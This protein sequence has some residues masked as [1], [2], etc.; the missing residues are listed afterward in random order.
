MSQKITLKGVGYGISFVELTDE[1][2]EDFLTEVEQVDDVSEIEL[3]SDLVDESF[4]EYGIVLGEGDLSFYVDDKDQGDLL[5]KVFEASE[6]ATTDLAPKQGEN[7]VVYEA[8]ECIDCTIEVDEF[9]V[10][11]FDL[12]KQTLHL[13][14]GETR[15]IA[16]VCYGDIGFDVC[17]TT[18][19][20]RVYVVTKDQ[21]ILAF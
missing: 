13:P 3:V 4:Y 11:R 16:T 14:N 6:S 21:E 19:Y 7:L 20:G 2:L 9:D 18:S 10:S 1:Q 8:Q 5:E 12:F 17:D 15:T